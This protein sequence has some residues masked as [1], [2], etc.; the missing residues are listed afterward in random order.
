M[1]LQLF[2]LDTFLLSSPHPTKSRCPPTQMKFSGSERLLSLTVF[3]PRTSVW[4]GGRALVLSPRHCR[5]YWGR[6]PTVGG[7]GVLRRRR[8]EKAGW[9]WFTVWP[10]LTVTY[11]KQLGVPVVSGPER[12]RFHSVEKPLQSCSWVSSAGSAPC[13]RGT[14]KWPLSRLRQ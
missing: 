10:P 9:R 5:G 11:C 8:Q 14:C 12:V 7:R 1:P 2:S 3:I 6:E 4:V 13:L